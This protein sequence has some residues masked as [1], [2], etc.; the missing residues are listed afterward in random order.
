MASESKG[1]MSYLLRGTLFI[2]PIAVTLFILKFAFGLSEEWLGGPARTVVRLL[3][4]KSWL[5]GPFADGNIPGLSMVFLVVFLVC[6]GRIASWHFGR[7]K[8]R[9]IDLLFLKIPG[10]RAVY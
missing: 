3:L 8:L 2:L 6:L 10:V 7:E 5:V 9:L 1:L 4:P